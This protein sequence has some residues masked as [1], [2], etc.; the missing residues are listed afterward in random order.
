[1]TRRARRGARDRAPVRRRRG[2]VRAHRGAARLR[3]AA[4]GA[5]LP[6]GA[7]P[8]R[9]WR[10]TASARSTI[11]SRAWGSRTSTRARRTRRRWRA[12]TALLEQLASGIRLREP[13]RD[14]P[15]LRT[16]QGRRGLRGGAAPSSTSAIARWLPRLR[17]RDL[18]VVTADHGVDPSH[19]GTDHTRE[20]APL[21]AV[22]GSMVASVARGGAYGGRRHDGPLADV[23]ASVLRW[24]AGRDGR[25]AAGGAVRRSRM[26]PSRGIGSVRRDA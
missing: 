19:A 2:R 6:A 12:W 21:L 14:R 5:Q 25:W 20:Y 4:A 3:A 11:C 16:P 8:T 7:Q 18:L 9:A 15:D 10:S 13:D 23:G 24:L 22:T 26:R 17:E 1:M